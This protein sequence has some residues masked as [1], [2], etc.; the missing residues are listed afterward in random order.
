M[1][2]GDVPVSIQM[3]FEAPLSEWHVLVLG[4]HG[5]ASIDLFRDIVVMGPN[6]GRHE[7]GQVA[8]TSLAATLSHW[9]GYLRSGTGHVSGR[10]RYGADEVYRRFHDAVH[11]RP[12]PGI[13][14][15]DALA[16]ARVQDWV[17]D[18]A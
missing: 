10:L 13:A 9:R 6:D 11:G 15:A 3:S 2:A 8:R 16:I 7:A 18:S 12:A 4:E 5:F 14:A 1:R 17:V